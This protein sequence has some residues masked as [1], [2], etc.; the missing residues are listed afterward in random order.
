MWTIHQNG[1]LIFS[2]GGNINKANE[3]AKEHGK[4]KKTYSINTR[5][6]RLIASS[7]V[8]QFTNK[9]C[10]IGF[11]TFT[12]P[13]EVNEEQATE[14][15]SRFLDNLKLN[16][17]LKSIIYVKEIGSNNNVH[18]HA[19][20]EIPRFNFANLKRAWFS[21]YSRYSNTFANNNIRYDK[22]SGYI[23]RT[24]DR[25]VKYICKY[26]AKG[27]RTEFRR[28]CYGIS[29]HIRGDKRR[30]TE[31]DSRMILDSIENIK[32]KK[33]DFFAIHHTGKY[34]TRKDFNRFE[35]IKGL[36]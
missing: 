29:R 30:I 9:K 22:K 24:V 28:R 11:L 26:A 6:Y 5:V 18:F 32:V 15:F 8:E 34:F 21:A 19:L 31:S 13:L 27:R 2:S 23:V 4:R 35:T 36:N 3:K 16:Y 33:G 7:A 25:A 1:D 20:I 14:S 10:N 17:K 12:L